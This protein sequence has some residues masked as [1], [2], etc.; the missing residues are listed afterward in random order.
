M[1]EWKER[2]RGIIKSGGTE[3]NRGMMRKKHACLLIFVYPNVIL[4]KNS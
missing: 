4:N 2:R 1:A 3:E